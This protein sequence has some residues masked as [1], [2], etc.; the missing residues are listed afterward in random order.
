MR[1]RPL[2]FAVLFPTA[3]VAQI[4]PDSPMVQALRD[5]RASVPAPESQGAQVIVEKI[6]HKTGSQG[7]V[8]VEF[9]RIEAF[10]SQPKCG[11]VGYAFYQKSSNTFWGQF[12]GQLNI[13]DDGSP[14]ERECPGQAKLVA[15]TAR[16]ADGSMARDTPEV[17]AALAR[18][19]AGGSLTEA[20]F[21]PKFEAYLKK[22]VVKK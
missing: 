15:A 22:G 17:K 20:Q 14:P 8:T 21:K 5:G 12:G 3:V 16:C 18:A 10:T 11:R 7:E 6:K 4:S 19:V 13:C 1:I 9:V 2:L